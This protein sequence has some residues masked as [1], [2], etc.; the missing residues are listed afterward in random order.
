MA[1]FGYILFIFATLVM[2]VPDNLY[3]RGK[4]NTLEGLVKIKSVGTGLLFISVIFMLLG[5]R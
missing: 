4:I 3:R 5:N 2:F 1:I